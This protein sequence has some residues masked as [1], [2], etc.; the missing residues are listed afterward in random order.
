MSWV[1]IE[2]KIKNI[3]TLCL[4]CFYFFLFLTM[5]FLNPESDKNM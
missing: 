4:L 3:K 1:K 5:I 2:I